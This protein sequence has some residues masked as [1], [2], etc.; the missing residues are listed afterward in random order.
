MFLIR[1]K[2]S[3]II[4]VEVFREELQLRAWKLEED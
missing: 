1:E 2:K 3:S 4:K